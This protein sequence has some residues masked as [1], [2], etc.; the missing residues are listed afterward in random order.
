M[1]SAYKHCDIC[2]FQWKETFIKL[3]RKHSIIH[4]KILYNCLS[5]SIILK[6]C[7]FMF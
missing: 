6:K 7:I 4:K 1:F 2:R 3:N 5:L